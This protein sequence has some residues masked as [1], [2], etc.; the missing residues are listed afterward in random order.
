MKYLT[1]IIVTILFTCSSLSSQTTRPTKDETIDLWYGA[2]RPN[3]TTGKYALIQRMMVMNE[4]IQYISLPF[5]T[6]FN[7]LNQLPENLELRPNE[8]SEGFLFE[9]RLAPR[10]VVAR[11]RDDQS[12]FY[13]SSRVTLDPDFIF[14]L[15]NGGSIPLLPMN[16]KLGGTIEK[17]FIINPSLRDKKGET[18]NEPELSSDGKLFGSGHSRFG[19][20]I[21]STQ[22]MHY[23]N[24]Q[25]EGA[26]LYD[27]IPYADSSNR[28]DYAAGNFS[29]YYFKNMIQYSAIN[30]NYAMFTAGVGYRWDLKG[31]DHEGEQLGKYGLQRLLGTLQYRSKPS[32]R[33]LIFRNNRHHVPKGNKTEVVKVPS[34]VEHVF[35]LD[36]E[37][38]TDDL[39]RFDDHRVAISARYSLN[40]MYQRSLGYFIKFH[41]GRDYLNIRYDLPVW[42]VLAGVTFDLYKQSFPEKIIRRRLSK[43]Y[44]KM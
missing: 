43:V 2:Y 31:L 5:L 12:P 22:F 30:A 8:G 14:R 15:T 35:R 1:L 25:D 32:R 24:G 16:T 38:I 6:H 7:E 40:P 42:S 28:N 27:S 18:P 37:A 39:S 41:Y 34:L 23:S 44:E 17:G 13:R 9:G 26:L 4:D 29:T 20:F 19:I 11:G 3:G 36:I 10:I 21:L 33:W